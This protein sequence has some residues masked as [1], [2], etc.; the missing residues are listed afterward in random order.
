MKQQ[1]SNK[2][3]IHIATEVKAEDL[4]KVFGKTEDEAQ[5]IINDLFKRGCLR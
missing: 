2:D 3:E 1:L 5:Q 4:V